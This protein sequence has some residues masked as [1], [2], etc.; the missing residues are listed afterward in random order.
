MKK[1]IAA[2]LLAAGA[3]LGLAP[4]ASAEIT[5]AQSYAIGQTWSALA[6]KA[7]RQ[8]GVRPDM[9]L[10]TKA[11][12]CMLVSTTIID[13]DT[14]GKWIRLGNAGFSIDTALD[15]CVAG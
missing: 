11:D 10:E 14:S 12:Y 8:Y 2:G 13:N 1:I 7:M 9:G 5:D 6:V 4:A 3:L 15:G